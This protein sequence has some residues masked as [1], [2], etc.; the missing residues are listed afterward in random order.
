MIEFV[1]EIAAP[2]YV[3]IR[4]IHVIAVMAWVWRTSVAYAFYL[5]PIFKAWRRNPGDRDLITMRNWA[6]ERFDEGAVYEHV[7][8]PLIM[9]TGPLLYI[10]G[11]WNAGV[12]WLMLKLLIVFGIFLP[13][14]MMDY[15]L[16]HGAG[17]KTKIRASGDM[18][19]YETAVHRHWWFL[20]LTSPTVM[21]FAFAIILLATI[22]P[23]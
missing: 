3:Y 6:I 17:N 12:G 18:V 22:R 4:A 9:I 14:E 13:I 7:A 2:Y 20:L 21:I 19:A 1:R 8:F 23:I 10:I 11:G 16:S 15:H 5:V